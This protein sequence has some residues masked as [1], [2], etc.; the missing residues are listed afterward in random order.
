MSSHTLSLPVAF[1]NACY[2][3]GQ[4]HIEKDRSLRFHSG[5]ID[6]EPVIDGSV[7]LMNVRISVALAIGISK[8]PLFTILRESRVE[9]SPRVTAQVLKATAFLLDADQDSSIV[10]AIEAVEKS[11]V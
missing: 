9:D 4:S 11:M 5:N 3:L 7:A 6:F 8:T 2:D 1:K 10:Q